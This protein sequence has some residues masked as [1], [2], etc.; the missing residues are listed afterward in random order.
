MVK[1]STDPPV[2]NKTC[3]TFTLYGLLI[4]CRRYSPLTSETDH[5][6]FFLDPSLY[7]AGYKRYYH[8]DSKLIKTQF[9]VL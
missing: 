6:N 4:T 5:P 8:R 3:G 7:N 2:K 9:L 1:R